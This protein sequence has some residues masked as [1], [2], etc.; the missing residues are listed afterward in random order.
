M[1]RLKQRCDWLVIAYVGLLA[2]WYGSWLLI[3]DQGWWLILLH[4]SGPYLFTPIPLVL[5]WGVWRIK[6]RIGLIAVIP[7][8]ILAALVWPY[9]APSVRGPQQGPAL[10]VMTFN[11][12]FSNPNPQAVATLIETYKPDLIALQEVQNDMMGALIARL[13]SEYP[14]YLM[15][16]P[17]PYGTTAAFSRY[18]LTNTLVINLGADRAAV[19]LQ[20]TIQNQPVTFFS[21]HLLSYGLL[22]VPWREIPAT[23]EKFAMQRERQAQEL[24]RVALQQPDRIVLLGCDCNVPETTGVYRRLETGLTNTARRLGWWAPLPAYPGIDPDWDIRHFDYVFYRGALEP[25]TIYTIRDTAGSDHRAVVAEFTL[26]S[27]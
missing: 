6:D 2:L 18:P 13:S 4:H 10:R 7:L 25:H 22:W 12:L 20:M 21:A 27:Q 23:T 19:M 5:V 26:P 8:V 16:P 24:L 3:G 1:P 11:V 14:Y 17:H 15:G 9:P